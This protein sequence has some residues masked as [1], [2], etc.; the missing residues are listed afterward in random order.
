VSKIYDAV[1]ANFVDY[2]LASFLWL[3][4]TAVAALG[5]LAC[6]VGVFFTLFWAWLAVSYLASKV[7]I[8]AERVETPPAE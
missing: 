7:Y 1:K 8:S 6:G 5:V 2:L 4:Y 3:V